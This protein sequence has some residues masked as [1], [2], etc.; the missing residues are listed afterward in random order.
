MTREIKFRAWDIDKGMSK[1]FTIFE[2]GDDN[3]RQYIGDYGRI[4]DNTII[5][6]FTG[7]K[8]KNGN[9]IYEG[10]IVKCFDTAGEEVYNHKIEL[11][12]FY[13]EIWSDT[14]WDEEK[15]ERTDIT[16]VEIIG[17]VHK[18]PELLTPN[19]PTGE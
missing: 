9:L 18:S 4:Y 10:D 3:G 14:E 17:N 8:D 5:L 7:L 13:R 11:P 19:H 12:D 1:E 2:I 15:K 6:Q 16:K